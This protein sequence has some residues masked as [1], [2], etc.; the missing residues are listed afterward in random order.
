MNIVIDIDKIKLS[1]KMTKE[2]FEYNFPN[3]NFKKYDNVFEYSIT[4]VI[5]QM[6]YPSDIVVH[7][8]NNIIIQL[9]VFPSKE[10]I[11]SKEF[12]IQESYNDYNNALEIIYGKRIVNIFGRLK[13]WHFSDATLKHY[14]F[15]RFGMEE[16]IEVLFKK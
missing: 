4:G 11:N 8:K 14:L 12:N 6:N 5:F 7:F 2:E 3:A 13:I 16:R 9:S 15:E 1:S 10:K